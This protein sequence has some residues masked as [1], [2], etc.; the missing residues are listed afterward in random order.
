ML[1]AI[2]VD[3]SIGGSTNTALHL[4]A[5]AHEFGIDIDLRSF[6]QISR[7][8]KHITSIRPSGPYHIADLERAGGIPAILKRLRDQ[9]VRR[10]TPSPG[11]SCWTSR[12]RRTSPTR[13]WIRPFSRPFHE[14]G[15]IAVLYGNLRARRP[16]WSSR[17]RYRRR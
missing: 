10:G 1:N 11:P 16:R 13:K 3:M 14:Q 2:R 8:V 17:P 7:Q 6:D 5:I 12:T 4:P 9:A 15:G